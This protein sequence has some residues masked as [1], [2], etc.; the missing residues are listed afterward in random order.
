MHQRP[1]PR[2]PERDT[3]RILRSTVRTL[4]DNPDDAAARL[5]AGHA[6]RDYLALIFG[7]EEGLADAA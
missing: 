2:S 3:F 6:A 7:D 4:R 1:L 5:A